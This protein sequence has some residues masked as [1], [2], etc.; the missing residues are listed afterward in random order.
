[1]PSLLRKYLLLEYSL[2]NEMTLVISMLNRAIW[3]RSSHSTRAILQSF[4]KYCKRNIN[5]IFFLMTMYTLWRLSKVAWL[6]VKVK[7][8][9]PTQFLRKYFDFLLVKCI[10]IRIYF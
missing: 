1:M 5:W 8:N 2:E 10:Q 3:I 7:G 4:D 9:Q 6:S